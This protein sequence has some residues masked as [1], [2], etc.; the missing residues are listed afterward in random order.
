MLRDKPISR[1]TV[2][3]L[4]EMSE[5]NRATFYHHYHDTYDLLEQIEKELAEEILVP[6][7]SGLHTKDVAGMVTEI[8]YAIEKNEDLCRVIFSDHGDK[9]FLS[10]VLFSGHDGIVSH[11]REQY[12]QVGEERLEQFYTLFANGSA[13]VVRQWIL[14]EHREK[15]EK[16]AVFLDRVCTMG[17]K[18]LEWE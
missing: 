2:K 9:G 16:L 12:P 15:P 17:L 10:R 7:G 3:E 8:L 11:W 18:A 13:A 14:A 4:C 6:M 5:M 1:I